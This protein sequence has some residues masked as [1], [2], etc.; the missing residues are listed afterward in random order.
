MVGKQ[1][2]E[3]AQFLQDF[4]PDKHASQREAVR[5]RGDVSVKARRVSGLHMAQSQEGPADAGVR[6]QA[7]GQLTGVSSRSPGLPAGSPGGERHWPGVHLADCARAGV[8]GDGLLRE[9]R[10]RGGAVGG[11]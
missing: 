6:S 8:Y 5:H 7:S 9:G 1:Q 11:V 2:Y 10:V 3:Y 4:Q